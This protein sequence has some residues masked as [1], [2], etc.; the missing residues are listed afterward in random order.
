LIVPDISLLLYAHDDHSQFHQKA[1]AWWEGA[2]NGDESVGIPWVVTLGFVR[3]STSRTIFRFPWT[4]DESM[5]VVSRWFDSPVVW[6]IHPG[7]R[8]L[9]VLSQLMQSAQGGGKLVTD[10]HLA[11][12]AIEH[13]AT[14]HSHDRDFQRFSGLIIH[15]PLLH[16]RA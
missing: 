16:H 1:K 3:L 10:A 15:D 8:H 6:P 9:R 2:V 12:I 13:R 14:L 7:D 5:A 11:S 4:V